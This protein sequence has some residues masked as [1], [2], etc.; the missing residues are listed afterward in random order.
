MCGRYALHAPAESLA[1]DFDA[2]LEVAAL[3]PRYNAAPL[4]WLPVV[5]QR[6]SGERVIHALRW[7][8]L[9]A[10]AKDEGMAARL[11]NARAETLSER[12]AFR[13]AFGR[14]RCVIPASGF[15]EWARHLAGKQP[16]YLSPPDGSLLA[17]GGLWERWT[18]AA[19]GQTIDTFAIVTTAANPLV[20]ELHD[21]MPLILSADEV[22]LWLDQSTP[23]ARIQ[24]MLIPC[25]DDRLTAQ[26]VGRAVGNVRNEGPELIVPVGL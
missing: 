24:Q 2:I 19:D 4:Q 5:R 16:F 12:P 13:A 25:P 23:L 1:E 3:T 7:G 20:S 17:L 18:R 15:Y 14:R 6:P 8:L 22:G 10:W 26:P 21:R 11:I 9:P